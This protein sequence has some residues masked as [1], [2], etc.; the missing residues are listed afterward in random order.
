MGVAWDTL[1]DGNVRTLIERD[2]LMPFLQRQ[3]WFG[4]KARGVRS[5]RFIDWGCC[6]AAP[7]RCSSPSSTSTTRMASGTATSCRWR[8]ARP[9]MRA[10]SRSGHR[11]AVLARVTGARKGVLFDA[12]LDNGFGRALMETF[13]QQQDIRSRRGTLRAG[14]DQRVRTRPR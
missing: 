8:F 10:A 7:S 4:G 6:G 14:A 1:L 9:P 13:E 5:A 11:N 2:L 3:R 12:W